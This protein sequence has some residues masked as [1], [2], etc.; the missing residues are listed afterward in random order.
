MKKI[1]AMILVI[2]MVL[3]LCGTA[4]AADEGFVPGQLIVMLRYNVTVEDGDYMSLF[5]ELELEYV[6]EFE[7]F[8]DFAHITRIELVLVLKEKTVEATNAAFEKL[9]SNPN[10]GGIEYNYNR[11]YVGDIVKGDTNRDGMISNGDLVRLA[12]YIV[13]LAE[14]KDTEALGADFN[15][16]GIITNSDLVDLAKKLV[17]DDEE[18][19]IEDMDR[20][21]LDEF[22]KHTS[23]R[24]GRSAAPLVLL[25][26]YNECEA[27]YMGSSIYSEYTTT[28]TVGEYTFDAFQNVNLL[29][30]NGTG[31]KSVAE[32]HEA[33]WITDDDLAAV[34]EANQKLVSEY[35]E[36][37]KIVR[38]AIEMDE[39]K[40]EKLAFEYIVYASK[41]NIRPFLYKLT[42]YGTYSGCQ[43]AYIV[44]GNGGTQALEYAYAGGYTFVFPSSAEDIYVFND[45][46]VLLLE[47]A[48]NEGW[49]TDEDAAGIWEVY[50]G[51]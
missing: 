22:W 49:I 1:I 9:K 16:D 18:I 27:I 24:R 20:Y 40:E 46:D 31:L 10:I 4:L 13:G 47:L 30:Y 42:Y 25:G 29:M 26:T 32:A 21:L 43:V 34:Y 44:R 6:E 45:G 15:S 19:I 17:S 5:P 2:V 50:S 33:G 7:V 12:R 8:N 48:Y 14:L 36:E 41:N 51:N 39:E 23:S 3:S 11:Y 38:E 37:K 35:K 28:M